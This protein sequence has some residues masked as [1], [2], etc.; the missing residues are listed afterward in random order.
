MSKMMGN[1]RNYTAKQEKTNW[2]VGKCDQQCEE[3]LMRDEGLNFKF[4]ENCFN[5]N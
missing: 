5:E 2:W 3:W 4:R 1:E